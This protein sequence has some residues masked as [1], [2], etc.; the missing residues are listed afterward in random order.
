MGVRRVAGRAGLLVAVRVFGLSGQPAPE[1][2]R[3]MRI[4]VAS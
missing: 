2:A 3:A 1:R 4:D